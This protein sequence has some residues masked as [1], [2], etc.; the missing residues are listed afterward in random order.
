MTQNAHEVMSHKLITVSSETSL[1]G[2]LEIM[3]EHRI[4]HLPVVD[5][6][7]NVVGMVSQRDLSLSFLS[8]MDVD[9]VPIK[10]FMSAPVEY[11]DQQTSIRKVIFKM[12]EKKIS[13]VVISGENK[14]AIGLITTDDLLW[15]LAHLLEDETEKN[16]SLWD[17]ANLQTIGEVARRLSDIGI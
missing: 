9:E 6:N 4:R 3:A 13:C 16:R 1:L 11:L 14:D 5:E 12:L 7:L 10:L 8:S 17:I 2:T 15:Y